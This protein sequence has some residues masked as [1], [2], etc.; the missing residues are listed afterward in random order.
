MLLANALALTLLGVFALTEGEKAAVAVIVCGLYF[1]LAALQTLGATFCKEMGFFTRWFC[2]SFGVV[3]A[4]VCWHVVQVYSWW[5]E[6]CHAAFLRWHEA[7]GPARDLHWHDYVASEK[8]AME[9]MPLIIGYFLFLLFYPM[10]Y[11][12]VLRGPQC[13]NPGT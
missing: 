6:T 2:Y 9:H 12:L 7:T 4:L 13:L 1:V 11:H 10:S 5:S 3:Y 8:I